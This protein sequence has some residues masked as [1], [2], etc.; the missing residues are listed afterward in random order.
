VNGRAKHEQKRETERVN[1]ESPPPCF[2][3]GWKPGPWPSP[4]AK[5]EKVM[6]EVFGRPLM[7]AE[8][9]LVWAIAEAFRTG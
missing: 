3:A 9:Q 4:C 1:S 7:L 5:V 2:S 6:R 8:V